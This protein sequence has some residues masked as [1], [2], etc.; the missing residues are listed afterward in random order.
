MCKEITSKLLQTIKI[1][2]CVDSVIYG[3]PYIMRE[4]Q[5]PKDIKDK[6]RGGLDLPS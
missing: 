2:A 5:S 4:Q 6:Y 1:V 3:I